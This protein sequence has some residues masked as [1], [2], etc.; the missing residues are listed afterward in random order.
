MA[1]RLHFTIEGILRDSF[2]R[3][4]T[5]GDMVINGLLR[6]EWQAAIR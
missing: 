6:R 3:N 2:L 5:L 4:G 1:K